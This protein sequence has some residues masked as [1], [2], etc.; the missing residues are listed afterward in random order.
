MSEIA[1]KKVANFWRAEFEPERL[2]EVVEVLREITAGTL[3]EEPGTEIQAFHIELPNTIW[4]YALFTDDAAR[5]AHRARV[6]GTPPEFARFNALLT[7]RDTTREAIPAAA[8][9]VDFG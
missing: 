8:K 3:T 4:L 2:D 9:G 7:H 1:T 6:E 5:V